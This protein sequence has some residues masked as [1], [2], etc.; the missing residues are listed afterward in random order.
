MKSDSWRPIKGHKKKYF[1]SNYGIVMSFKRHPNGYIL[2]P[3]ISKEGYR[4]YSLDGRHYRAHCLVLETFV[5][6][7][8]SPKHDCRHL[9]GDPANNDISNLAWGTRTENV[10]D[11][12]KHGTQVRGEKQGSSKLKAHEVKAIRRRYKLGERAILLAKEYGICKTNIYYVLN[13]K[14]WDHVK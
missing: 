6:P 4:L 12:I 5:G 7:R 1:I 8:P 10:H 9:D 11:M 13:R 2:K 3:G 14:Y